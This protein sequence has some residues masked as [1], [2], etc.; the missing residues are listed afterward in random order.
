M[1][2]IKLIALAL[3]VLSTVANA[4]DAMEVFFEPG[5]IPVLITAPHG[6]SNQPSGVPERTGTNIDGNSV[7][8]FV[9]VKDSYTKTIAKNIADEYE[10]LY[11][12]RP[13]VVAANFHRKYIDANRTI[14]N[15]IEH[16]NAQPFYNFYHQ[17]VNQ[18]IQQIKQNYQRGLLLDIHGQASLPDKI[19][20]GSRNGFSVVNLVNRHS[21]QSVVGAHSIFGNLAYQGYQLEPLNSSVPD[22]STPIV[23]NYFPGGNTIKAYGSQNQHG[24]EALQLE[25]GKNIRF[26]S[27][28]RTQLAIDMANNINDF[29]KHYFCIGSNKKFPCNVEPIIVDRDHHS[30]Y[31]T[32]KW[33]NSSAIDNYPQANVSLSQYTKTEGK[34]FTWT[35]QILQGNYYH[36]WAWWTNEKSG[37][38]SYER[39]SSADYQITNGLGYSTTITVNQNLNAGR[40][41]YLTTIYLPAGNHNQVKLQRQHDGDE[42]KGTIADAV[43][44]TVAV[45]NQ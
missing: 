25:I 36:V 14:N 1:K 41:N 35:P 17:K 21:W 42:G 40:W 2:T 9:K 16:V 38:G 10:D 45:S 30:V 4:E 31:H 20:R 43:A 29:I 22:T 5:N 8:D 3:T 32:D 6:G 34:Y 23:E 18:Y 37:G 13:Y 24:L 33:Y 7:I 19:V 44:F 39:D 12:T 26:S 27:S 15:A 11:G 28:A